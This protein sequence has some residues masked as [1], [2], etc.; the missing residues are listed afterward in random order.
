MAEAAYERLERATAGLEAPFALIDLDALWANAQD[1]E[2]RAAGTPLRL[3]SKSLRCRELQRRTLE[4]DGFQGTLAF[5]LPEAI[6]LAEEGFDDLVVAY[7]STDAHAFA[8]LVSDARLASAITVMVD[9]AEQLDLIQNA[10]PAGA[11]VQVCIDVDAGWRALGGRIRVGARRSPVR[12]PEQA[13]ALASEIVS[14]GERFKLVGVMAY[15]AQIAGVGDDPPGRR[16]RGAAIR[17]MQKRS[18]RE[19]AP[20]RAAAVAAI[21]GVLSSH[22]R[23]PLRFVNAGGTGSI[24]LSRSEPAVS[25]VSAGS[26]LYGPTLFDAYTAFTPRPAAMFALP[27]VR[28]PGPGVVTALGGGYLAS[29]PADAAR[30]PRPFLPRGLQLDSREGAGEVQT[31]LLG[32]P[33][34]DLELGDRVYFRH[35]KAGELSERFASLHLVEG[36]RVVEEL[37]TYRGEGRCFL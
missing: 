15:E 6:W 12:A 32:A 14:R 8:A 26:G 3:A 9:S 33:A 22:G 30:L 28:R 18:A 20:R 4:R 5:T 2:A 11:A 7:P 10:S 27:I 31:P 36:D 1:M 37:P 13:A 23:A 25:E 17:A 34:D 35:A 24:E 29:G 16:L 21:E 19:L